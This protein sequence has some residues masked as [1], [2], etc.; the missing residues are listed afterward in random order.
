VQFSLR[1][2]LTATTFIAIPLA[3]LSVHPGVLIV[4]LLFLSPFLLAAAMASLSSHISPSKWLVLTV[5]GAIVALCGVYFGI[6]ASR[7]W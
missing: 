4:S 7:H 3:M 2:L 6:E 1:S 5:V